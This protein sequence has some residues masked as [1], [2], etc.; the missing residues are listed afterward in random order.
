MA[1]RTGAAGV[2]S[3]GLRV[4]TTLFDRAFAGGVR[5]PG[6]GNLFSAYQDYGF[7]AVRYSPRGYDRRLGCVWLDGL[8]L[9]DVLEGIPSYALAAALRR[10]PLRGGRLE[11]MGSFS[12]PGAGSEAAGVRPSLLRPGSRVAVGA[13]GRSYGFGARASYTGWIGQRDDPGFYY[14]VSASRRWGRDLYVH[15]VFTDETVVSASAEKRIGRKASLTLFA[16]AAPV[17]QGVRQAATQEC[18][19]LVGDDLYNPAWGWWDGKERS[20]RVRR[21]MQPFLM[22][23]YRHQLTDRMLLRAVAGYRFGESAVSSLSWFSAESPYPDY[24]RSLPSY[25]GQEVGAAWKG[26]N[27]EY[28]QID[29]AGMVE[30]NRNSQS[31]AVYAVDE[32][33]VDIDSWQGVLSLSNRIGNRVVLDLG[34]RLRSDGTDYFRRLKDDLEGG[35]VYNVDQYLIDDTYYGERVE[36]DMTQPGRI[37]HEDER[38]GYDYRI[39]G[40]S[41]E[42]YSTLGYAAGRFTLDAGLAVGRSG[43][44]RVGRYEKQTFPGER[45]LGRSP[46]AEFSTY[47]LRAAA[48]YEPWP[49]CLVS[50][51]AL[52]SQAAPLF[53]DVFLNPDYSNDRMEGYKAVGV[54][55][56]EA[57]VLIEF[58]EWELS[59]AGYRTAMEN[60]SEVYRYYDDISSLY[61]DLALSGISKLHYG[62]EVGLRARLGRGLD[63]EAAFAAGKHIYNSDPVSVIRADVDGA[64]TAAGESVRLKDF[65][66]GG[67]PQ[68][69][70]GAALNWRPGRGAWA[71]TAAVNCMADNYVFL[72]PV[73]RMGRTINYLASSSESVAEFTRQERMPTATTINLSAARFFSLGGSRRLTVFGSVSNL[74]DSAFRYYGYEQMRLKK[75]GSGLTTTYGVFDSKYLNGYGR[76]FYLSVSFLF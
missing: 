51:S 58:G 38:Y 73:R 47:A 49:G 40:D 54:F 2:R 30:Q 64:V 68:T 20:S 43:F 16:L 37:V 63:V 39:E 52:K 12:L 18:Y 10:V 72:N 69:V 44:E 15:G 31:G 4:D 6:G 5:R 45:S 65:A 23:E 71:L 75:S 55:S 42:A 50:L 70:A 17:E 33:V 62:V 19:D 66:V 74:L 14:N 24:Y 57:C 35:Y 28:T 21:S 36:N 29:W 59:V 76:T 41:W 56:V 22:A 1:G 26:R 34:V 25:L 3:G 11:G 32:R 53:R 67:T 27:A 61:S 48:G 7:S 46:R 8:E 60:A 9:S 13:T